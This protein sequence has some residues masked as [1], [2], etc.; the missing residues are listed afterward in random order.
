M[1]RRLHRWRLAGLHG[2][3]RARV[4]C[5]GD[6][7]ME[8]KCTR[9]GGELSNTDLQ[10]DNTDHGNQWDCIHRLQ[11]TNAKLLAACKTGLTWI[12][13]YGKGYGDSEET[14]KIA[15]RAAIKNAEPEP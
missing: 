4:D 6:K 10:Y 2:L 15:L 5:E 8:G 7:V 13:Y 14:A 9:C 1:Q 12:E 11:A 3:R